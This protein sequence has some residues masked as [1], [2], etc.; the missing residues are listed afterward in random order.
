MNSDERSKCFDEIT[1]LLHKIEDPVHLSNVHDWLIGLTTGEPSSCKSDYLRLLEQT[2][3]SDGGVRE[4]FV[5]PPPPALVTNLNGPCVRPPLLLAKGR[6]EGWLAA[7]GGGNEC[8]CDSNSDTDDGTSCTDNGSECRSSFTSECGPAAVAATPTARPD[9]VALL[10]RTDV[11]T[12]TVQQ[13]LADARVY[14]C[15]DGQLMIATVDEELGEFGTTAEAVFGE[16]TQRLSDA[17]AKEQ[18]TLLLRYRGNRQRVLSRAQIL[19]DHVRELMP[20]FQYDDYAAEP[21]AYIRRMVANRVS[22]NK[23]GGGGAERDENEDVV[24]Q[25]KSL[26]ALNWLRSEMERADCEYEVLSKR[27]DAIAAAIGAADEKRIAN[28]YRAADHKRKAKCEL[29]ELRRQSAKQIAQ[30][31]RYVERMS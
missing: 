17:L 29:I 5:H 14:T 18:A 13:L 10:N 3:K 20:T 30:I 15:D 22:K 2:L 7:G 8:G 12:A 31:D 23:D 25:K 24:R 28:E 21:D 11:Q 26:C 19:Q 16:R 4:P 6:T 9:L 1:G 27:H